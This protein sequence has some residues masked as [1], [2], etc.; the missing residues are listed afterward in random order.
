MA[1]SGATA[2]K[3]W[4]VLCLKEVEKPLLALSGEALKARKKTEPATKG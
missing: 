1:H 2:V 4:T 3:L